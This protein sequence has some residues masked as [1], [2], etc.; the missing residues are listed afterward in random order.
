[1]DGVINCL[2]PNAAP[3]AVRPAIKV[4]G[5][6]I[7]CKMK[8]NINRQCLAAKSRNRLSLG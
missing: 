7:V 2:I 6:G 1:M 8:D 4:T 5:D 3:K